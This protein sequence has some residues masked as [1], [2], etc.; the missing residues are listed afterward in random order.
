M[1]GSKSMRGEAQIARFDYACAEFPRA[2]ARISKP[3]STGVENESFRTGLWHASA[4]VRRLDF[5]SGE[6]FFK[7][8]FWWKNPLSSTLRRPRKLVYQY[9]I[10]SILEVLNAIFFIFVQPLLRK[11]EVIEEKVH[12]AIFFGVSV[13]KNGSNVAFNVVIWLWF[14]SVKFSRQRSTF[15]ESF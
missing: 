7:I 4:H 15:P 11:L 13:P 5:W 3:V 14:L 6:P 8:G 12:E 2:Y 1:V 9:S 10:W